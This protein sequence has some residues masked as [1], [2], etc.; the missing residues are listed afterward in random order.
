MIV[1]VATL[2]AEA[3]VLVLLMILGRGMKIT[4]PIRRSSEAR[5][6][7]V[8]AISVIALVTALVWTIRAIGH[9][10]D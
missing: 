6:K 1:L 2:I 8:Y 3:A 5:A 4:G 7:I 9:L 10:G